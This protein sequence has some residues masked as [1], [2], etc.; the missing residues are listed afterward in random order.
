MS[1]AMRKAV[2]RDKRRLKVGEYDLDLTYITPRV[3]AM[4]FPAGFFFFSKQIN[5]LFFSERTFSSPV[6]RQRRESL[7]KQHQRCF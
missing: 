5:C 7:E 6:N 2:S 1:Q 3:I 4:G